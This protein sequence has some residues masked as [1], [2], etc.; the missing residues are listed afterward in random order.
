[1]SPTFESNQILE[2][3]AI[4]KNQEPDVTTGKNVNF[5][6][7]YASVPKM[8]QTSQAVTWKSENIF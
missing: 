6:P 4:L 8:M 7:C 2:L 1:M 3:A 5:M